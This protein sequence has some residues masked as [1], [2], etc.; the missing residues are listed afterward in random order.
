MGWLLSG[1]SFGT[2]YYGTV[3]NLTTGQTNI[4]DGAVIIAGDTLRFNFGPNTNEWIRTG[5][6]SDTPPG[7][8]VEDAGPRISC[9]YNNYFVGVIWG[10][11]RAPETALTTALF[12]N[13]TVNPPTQTIGGVSNE[14]LSCGQYIEVND[15]NFETDIG[16]IDCEV[17][18]VSEKTTINPTLSFSPTYGKI[19]ATAGVPY[20]DS[21][22]EYREEGTKSTVYNGWTYVTQVIESGYSYN[23]PVTSRNVSPTADWYCWSDEKENTTILKRSYTE[24]TD[25]ANKTL[26]AIWGPPKYLEIPTTYWAVYDWTQSLNSWFDNEPAD[27]LWDEDAKV[28]FKN[29][30]SPIEK[31]VLKRTTYNG[32]KYVLDTEPFVQNI[33]AKTISYTFNIQPPVACTEENTPLK[34]NISGPDSGVVGT[35]YNFTITPNSSTSTYQ[36][37][38][39]NGS[40][41]EFVTNP[42]TISNSWS[43]TGTKSIKAKATD[44]ISRC[45]I[46]GDVKTIQ[47]TATDQPIIPNLTAGTPT[48]SSVSLSWTEISGETY[49][50][51]NA[52]TNARIEESVTSPHPLTGL[53]QNKTY[54]YKLLAMKG[55]NIT[56]SS[57][58]TVNTPYCPSECSTN[59]KNACNSGDVVSGSENSDTDK[60]YW[61]CKNGDQPAKSCELN[62][63][64]PND[65]SVVKLKIQPKIAPSC[66]VQLVKPNGTITKLTGT[67]ICD[68]SGPSNYQFDSLK[69]ATTTVQKP[70][71]Y[72]LKCRAS[73]TASKFEESTDVCISNPTT[74]ER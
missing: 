32:T 72:T 33:P 43:A 7:E 65:A 19:Y 71:L 5:A 62:K 35:T 70:G 64:Q 52:E 18:S 54:K 49:E 41:W 16:Y 21:L 66:L 26:T 10:Q 4:T 74:I 34:P 17:K 28:A 8:W 27:N 37:D 51:Y 48:C 47:I 45:S 2:R 31:T 39:G 1:L 6:T 57:I 36:I 24:N 63:D 40:G 13:F 55:G 11:Q 53:D 22:I 23:D 38:W 46:E 69:P 56:P 59:I 30:F 68:L 73:S 60:Y 15:N 42:N 20:N 25:V 50:L 44:K 58:V 61:S 29:L 9:D 67:E 3:D 14:L 12:A